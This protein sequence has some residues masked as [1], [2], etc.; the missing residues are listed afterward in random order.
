MLKR[1]ESKTMMVMR[2]QFG[3]EEDEEVKT[4]ALLLKMGRLQP[5]K[6]NN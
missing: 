1:P 3:D 5:S 2:R 4:K 6:M